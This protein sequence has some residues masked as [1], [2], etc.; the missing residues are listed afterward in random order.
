MAKTRNL[1]NDKKS[2]AGKTQNLVHAKKSAWTPPADLFDMSGMVLDRRREFTPE[3]VAVRV[4]RLRRGR[5]AAAA[6]REAERREREAAAAAERRAQGRG[7][8]GQRAPRPDAAGRERQILEAIADGGWYGSPDIF[9]LTRM[10]R[11]SVKALVVKM[12]RGGKLE[13][14]ANPAFD[15][16]KPP[17]RQTEPQWLFRRAAVAR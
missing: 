13:R 5:E 15:P 6:R 2:P 12:V 17:G 4:E 3:E 14:A 10:P 1:A 11:G 8:G 16:S 9:A 7:P